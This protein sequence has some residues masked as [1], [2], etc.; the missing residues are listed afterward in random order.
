MLCVMLLW[1]TR[2]LSDYA[3]LFNRLSGKS[4]VE[5]GRIGANEWA[6]FLSRAG[7]PS[8]QKTYAEAHR[9]GIADQQRSGFANTWAAIVQAD[10]LLPRDANIYLNVPNG[11][12][13]YYGTMIWYPRRLDVNTKPVRIAGGDT[14]QNN[15]AAVDANQFGELR[16]LGYTH[17]ITA[18]GLRLLPSDGSSGGGKP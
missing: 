15:S 8:S 9:R 6:S 17:I 14:L 5:R 7:R 13:Y 2:T 4:L 18:E 16:R 12:L 11:Q 10:S 1:S 3:G